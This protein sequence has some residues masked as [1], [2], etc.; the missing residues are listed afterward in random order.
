MV[1]EDGTGE[2]LSLKIWHFDDPE[3]FETLRDVSD[4]HRL[5]PGPGL[6]GRTLASAKPTW[7]V[8]V[9][10]DP[11]FRRAKWASD[12]GVKAGF[13]FPVLVG[14]EVV[15]VLEFFSTEARDP[16]E[17]MLEVMGVVGTQLGRV[18]ERA[19][20]ETARFNS[21]IDNMPANVFLR[22]KDGRFILVNRNYEKFYGVSN[23]AIRGKTLSEV[24]GN[25]PL[26]QMAEEFS[27]NDREVIE[28]NTAIER[29]RKILSAGDYHTMNDRT[30]PI[31]DPS[32]EVIA[33]GGVEIDITDRKRA[34]VTLAEKETQLRLALDSMPGGMRLVDRDLK[35][36]LFNARC[37]L[38]NREAITSLEQNYF[39]SC[40]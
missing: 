14:E 25:S 20:S 11:T 13:A 38:F 18:V 40:T 6:A 26:S 34:E 12:I 7:I 28:K 10:E 4:A 2:L 31:T 17:T 35:N 3:R 9:T 36:V 22:D 1:A 30:F 39:W 37:R 21:V 8:D 33:V 32:G 27:K 19:R 29:E 5:G 15:A 23:D 16:D 24:D